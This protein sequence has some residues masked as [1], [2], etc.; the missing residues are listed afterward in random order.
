MIHEISMRF[1]ESDILYDINIIMIK[2]YLTV[3]SPINIISDSAYN[4]I[5]DIS[6]SAATYQCHIWQW[7]QLSM[8][9]LKVLQLMNVVSDSATTLLMSY[10]T[11]LQ[12]MNVISDCAATFINVISNTAATYSCLWKGF[13]FY[14]C[15]NTVVAFQRHLRIIVVC[16]RHPRVVVVH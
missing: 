15:S 2:L 11:V 1:S 7:C 9:Y 12:L 6:N 14:C 3:L 8:S 5:N 10:L 16:T 4:S 13:G